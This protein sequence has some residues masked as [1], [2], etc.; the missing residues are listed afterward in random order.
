MSEEL[1]VA[2]A[3]QGEKKGAGYWLRSMF[4]DRAFD[5][6]LSKVAGAVL[7]N[8]GLIGAFC[9]MEKDRVAMLLAG[10]ITS[11]LGKDIRENT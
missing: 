9:G 8:A 1:K 5:P 3:W 7:V 10:G 2:E 11:I 6:C 4:G